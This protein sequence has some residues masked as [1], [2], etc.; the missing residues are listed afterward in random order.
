MYVGA[1]CMLL[2][3]YWCIRYDAVGVF[4]V[5]VGMYVGMYTYVRVGVHVCTLVHTVCCCGCV[6]V[7]GM[8]QW[9]CLV[10]VL[11]CML[12]CI[13]ML[14]SMLVWVLMYVSWCILYVAVGVLVYTVFWCWSVCC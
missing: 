10:W 5:D 2:W 12:V 6:G 1:Y 11:V 7:Y 13:Y 8:L 4:G 9:V 14:V 3:V